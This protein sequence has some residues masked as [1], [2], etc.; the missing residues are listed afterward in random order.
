MN[1]KKKS[2]HSPTGEKISQGLYSV[3]SLPTEPH[4]PRGGIYRCNWHL[5]PPLQSIIVLVITQLICIM[6]IQ[7]ET[8][9]TVS[10]AMV[11]GVS[12]I[13]TLPPS[14][15]LY[16]FCRLKKKNSRKIV[17]W[18]TSYKHCLTIFIYFS[19]F[20]KIPSTFIYANLCYHLLQGAK[21]L[22][23]MQHC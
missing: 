3:H 17:S 23:L 18:T 5:K 14:T 8:K 20:L 19:L 21:A 12:H 10:G 4:P 6:F 7:M 2:S 13:Y 11:W 15:T 22:L 9:R 1:M 16:T